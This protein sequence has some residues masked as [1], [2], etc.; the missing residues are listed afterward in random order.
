MPHQLAQCHGPLFLRER[1]HVHLNLVVEVQAALLQQQAN[2]GRSECR[3]GGADPEP[4][5]WR[6]G[7]P[8]LEIRPAKAF[9]PH[10]V[11]S[12]TDRHRESWQVLFDQT[13]TDDLPPLLHGVGPLWQRGRTR[14][15]WHLLRVRVQRRCRG[16]RERPDPK[17]GRKQEADGPDDQRQ[18]GLRANFHLFSLRGASP[19]GL[20]DTRPRSRPCTRF[21]A[22]S[23]RLG[24]TLRYKV[25]WVNA[26]LRRSARS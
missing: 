19:L 9:G 11:A 7:H 25:I 14:H 26:L 4:H 23:K 12:D 13:R 5:F 18:P 10:D 16:A 2:R 24:Y 3:G 20:P 22:R 21:T 15:G 17:N 8:V 6:D 1:R